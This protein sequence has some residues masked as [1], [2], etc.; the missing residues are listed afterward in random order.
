MTFLNQTQF[1]KQIG[2]SKGYISQLKT[3][4]R[5]VF[6]ESE[7]L[8]DVEASIAKIVETADENRD[9]VVA[10]HEAE[11][12]ATGKQKKA[13]ES[14]DEIK[15]KFSDARAKEQHFK[16]LRAEMDYKKESGELVSKQDVEHALQD[17]VITF[18]QGLE[19]LP[20]L[21][22]PTMVN[23]DIDFIRATLRA[24]IE[25]GLTELGRTCKK[26]LDERS[27]V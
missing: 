27:S 9:D 10:R 24:G 5:L 17:M 7:K 14:S 21:L 18:R 19:N 20:N 4:G 16:A 26:I 23:K 11:R 15:I 13:D 6:D 2:K 25:D 22:A 12:A 8:V 3:A 1:A